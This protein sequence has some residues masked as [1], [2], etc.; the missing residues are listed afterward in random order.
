M[1]IVIPLLAFLACL[2]LFFI[3]K[4]LGNSAR[5]GK[6]EHSEEKEPATSQ[7]GSFQAVSVV[8]G[9]RACDGVRTLEGQR[10][11]VQEAPL[12]PLSGCDP[13]HC[14]CRYARFE[15]RRDSLQERR[16]SSSSDVN[17]YHYSGRLERRMGVDHRHRDALA[18]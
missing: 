1:S 18:G 14:S 5:L 11:L 2:G 10:F 12:I 8:P 9:E 17:R 3:R 7:Q 4:N 15:D 16:K 6:T 13:R